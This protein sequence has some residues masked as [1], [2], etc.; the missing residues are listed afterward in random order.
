MDPEQQA[1]ARLQQELPRFTGLSPEEARRLA[2]ELGV[3]LR[4]L[5]PGALHTMEFR[6]D[7]VTADLRGGRL[8][9]PRVG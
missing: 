5:E 2:A 1:V 9:D 8:A 4:V 3:T 6:S 7:R